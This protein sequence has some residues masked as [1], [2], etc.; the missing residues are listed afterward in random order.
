MCCIHHI[1]ISE[2]PSFVK[3]MESKE[4]TEGDPIVIECMAAGLP[5]PKLL[6]R[7]DGGNLIPTERHFFTAEDQL[8]VIVDTILSDAGIYECEMTNSL[9]TE[10]GFSKLTII[11]G[12]H[13]K[14]TYFIIFICNLALFIQI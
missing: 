13:F 7:K 14:F 5:K 8:L 12:M 11:P 6:W 2:S 10:K 9:G 3:P 1:H 4:I